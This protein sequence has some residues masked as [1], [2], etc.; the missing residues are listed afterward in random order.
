[1]LQWLS[2]RIRYLDVLHRYPF[3]ALVVTLLHLTYSRP[4]PP[5]RHW[6]I[7]DNVRIQSDVFGPRLRLL[8]YK[9]GKGGEAE[10][11]ADASDKTTGVN[12]FQPAN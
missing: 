2:P 5:L 9:V 1:M 10:V 7:S 3:R 4:Q 6:L 11:V 8:S 12:P